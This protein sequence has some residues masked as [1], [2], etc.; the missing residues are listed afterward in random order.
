[1][2]N[3]NDRFRRHHDA[4]IFLKHQQDENLAEINAKSK[5]T[6]FWKA[7]PPDGVKVV[8]W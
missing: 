5:D 8:S 7:S 2:D 3:Q 6:K 4:T 1:M